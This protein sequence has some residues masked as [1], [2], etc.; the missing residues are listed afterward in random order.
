MPADFVFLKSFPLTPNGKVDRR[1][2][3]A[4]APS[5]PRES[6]GFVAARDEFETRMVSLWEHVLS[7]RPIGVRDNFLSWA[8]ILFWRCG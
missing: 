5:D 8:A 4:P 3:P 2:L 7:K 1:A 6:E